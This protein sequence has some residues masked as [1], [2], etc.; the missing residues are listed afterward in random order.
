ML[1]KSALCVFVSLSVCLLWN[2]SVRFS[3]ET[4]QTYC[5]AQKGV[6]VLQRGVVSWTVLSWLLSSHWSGR[7]RVEG[8]GDPDAWWCLLYCSSCCHSS[9][10]LKSFHQTCLRVQTYLDWWVIMNYS[11]SLWRHWKQSMTMLQVC[12]TSSWV[13]LSIW[14]WLWT[15]N[16]SFNP[17][18]P[19]GVFL[20][21]YL[22]FIFVGGIP[23]FFLEIALGQF[24][25]AGSINVWNIAPLFKGAV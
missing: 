7:E 24:M 17:S 19:A 13:I 25:K 22:L 6:W 3:Q 15:R 12:L 4:W 16:S 11:V 2:I 1:C 21:P 18:P 14:L 9:C 23:I 10:H 8:C 5:W 20:I